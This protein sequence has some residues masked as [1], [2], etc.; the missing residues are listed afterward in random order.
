ME[1]AAIAGKQKILSVCTLMANLVIRGSLITFWI[2]FIL[3]LVVNPSNI[4]TSAESKA[5]P[6]RAIYANRDS[7][8]RGTLI[9]KLGS[10]CRWVILTP[11]P[12]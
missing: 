1:V 3:A 4:P 2:A 11:G 8:S 10:R 7:Q 9:R 12:L 5:V 6:V